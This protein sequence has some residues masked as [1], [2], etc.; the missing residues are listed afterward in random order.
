M[1]KPLRP[2][3]VTA[4]LLVLLLSF[5]RATGQTYQNQTY[6]FGLMP[7]GRSGADAAAAYNSWKSTYLTT[8][9][10]G[11]YRVKWQEPDK[12]VSEG[13]GYGMLLA[14]YAADR[15]VLDG[16]WLYYKDNR[17][18]NGAMNWL[19]SGCNT[20]VW[21][22]G[23]ATDAEID[24]AMALIVAHSLWGSAGSIHYEADAKSLINTIKVHQVEPNTYV[25][26]P[27]D[28]GYG[29]S[30]LTNPS[31]F[32]PAYFRLFGQFTN[33]ATF[34]NN[35][36]AKCYEIINNNLNVNGGATTGLVSDWCRA[37]GYYSQRAVDDKRSFD[38]KRYYYDA[39]R[40]PW[41]IA[42]DYLWHGTAAAKTYCTKTTNFVK[43][44]LGG[45]A[46]VKDGYYQNGTVFGT[47]HSPAFAGAFGCAAMAV[48][49][50]TDYQNHLNSSYT[51]TKTNAGGDY[52]GAIT[53]CLYLYCQTGN[54]YK[55]TLTS[56][57]D[58]QAPTAPT[59]LTSP[60]KTSSSVSLSWTAATDNVG[61][62]GY[63]VFIGTSTTP[64]ATSTTTGATVTGLAAATT[65]SFTVKARDAAGN[66]SAAGT[67]L[68]VTTSAATTPPT[69]NL[70][71]NKPA[72]S[73]ANES[74][75]L[76]AALAV[77]GSATTRWA[78]PFSDPQWLQ[79]DL[80]A[81]YAINRVV[82]SWETAYG[83]G[84]SIQVSS[85]GTNWTSIY[86]TT[87]GNGA[88]D[89]L[90]GL[91]GTGRYVR[92]YGTAR[93]TAWGYSL[94]EFEVYGTASTSPPPAG[95]NGTY[96][97][98]ARHSG[99]V[100]E[101]A[102]GSAADGANVQQW[103]D[104][105]STAQQWII[106]PTTD[107]YYKLVCKASGKALEV[108]YNLLTDGGNVHQWTYSGA[109]NQQWKLEDVGGGFYKI[110]ARHSG[111]G[112]DVAN[113]SLADGGN[114]HQWTYNGG[115][116]QQWQVTQLSTATAR[117]SF[118][119]AADAGVQV[120]PNPVTGGVLKLR[121]RSSASETA[122]LVLG[123]GRGGRQVTQS[124][125]LHAGENAVT[126]PLHGLPAGLYLLRVQRGTRQA[127]QKVVVW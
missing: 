85:N 39:C 35:V 34:W 102:N 72:T 123:D 3:F 109:N 5:H 112:L 30:D 73:S 83:S 67:A 121:I 23:G 110:T 47:W 12:T 7:A 20:A 69:G 126:V 18:A 108:S 78:S 62:T 98:T 68:S 92:L 24:A 41:R 95:F 16:L 115:T 87:T 58:T 74:T 37:D 113:A 99:K 49:N 4:L 55:P 19:I 29:G 17:D 111:K 11:R 119:T 107:G 33:D 82:L 103:T 45:Q 60:G 51:D 28:Y 70:A 71:L 14:V 53:Q 52:Y 31:Y 88:T 2:A 77:D 100:L 9:P 106:T 124:L 125:R 90:T 43:N 89:D 32:A 122:Q 59:G 84:Y 94:W 42:V 65:Y 104:N 97:I 75:A 118:K 79:V 40:T 101:V 10:N 54:F 66:R 63:E 93:A 21:Q 56:P 116:N 8:C 46:N 36:A 86:S 64:A 15:V 81:S 105:G 80:G 38:G 13:I 27:G 61:V 22:P 50:T 1:Q 44:T 96:K 57:A 127:V 76:G 25:L 91:S 120:Y 114:V 48:D 117:E 26:R 6:A